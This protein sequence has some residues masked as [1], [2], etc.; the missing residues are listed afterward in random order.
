MRGSK[1]FWGIIAIIAI[2]FAG[3]LWHRNQVSKLKS[4]AQNTQL[5]SDEQANGNQEQNLANDN[6]AS[7]D[8]TDYNA[9]CES[10]QSVKISDVSGDISSLTGKLRKVYPDD[11]ASAPFKDYLY[12]LEA[13]PTSFALTGQDLSKLDFFEDRTV[14]VQGVKN[15][16]KKELEV[17]ALKCTGVETNQ[18]I[19]GARKKLMSYIG[20]HINE[21]A[22]HK[23]KYKSWIVDTIDFVDENNV[24][25]EYY[26]TAQ[27]D[28]NA[29][30]SEDTSR[31]I[32]LET[33]AAAGGNFT[34]KVLAYWEMGEDD[35]VLKEGKDK[36]SSVTDLTTYQFNTDTQ[37][38][39]RIN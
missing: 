35:Y 38:W 2:I 21:I 7:E 3:F 22:P 15:T 29:N 34:A 32:L 11:S 1:F 28:E 23:A 30:V 10:G 16:D 9:L 20:A 19:I 27:D 17:A 24:Y 33:S 39:D 25:V 14:E 5:A 37:G 31:K 13:T 26:D 8:N 4:A 12:F 6:S 36:F 18:N